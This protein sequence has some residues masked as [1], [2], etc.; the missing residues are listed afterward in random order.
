[1]GSKCFIDFYVNSRAVRRGLR[2]TE[3]Y[4]NEQKDVDKI[5]DTDITGRNIFHLSVQREELL[6]FVLEKFEKV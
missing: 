6:E 2:I 3:K 4:L 5:T 1:M